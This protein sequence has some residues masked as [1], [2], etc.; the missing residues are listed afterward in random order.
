MTMD[1]QL[2]QELEGML[3]DNEGR[4]GAVAR[5][6]IER[7][8]SNR[9]LVEAGG[10]ANQGAA[11]NT[12]ATV[13]AI[14]EGTIPTSPSV[15]QQARR[16]VSNLLKT[17]T[18][19]SAMAIDYLTELRDRL[20]ERV[21]DA[22]SVE[23]EN[24]NLERADKVLKESLEKQPG[25]YVYTTP[26]YF[27]SLQKSD[28]DRFWFKVGKTDRAAGVR[29]GEQMRATG[30]PENPFLARVYRHGTMAPAEVEAKY[31][32]LLDAAG[33]DRSGARHAGREWFATNLEFLDAIA[34][35]L[36]CE[37]AM[38]VMEGEE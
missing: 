21:S 34:T 6:W 32:L 31:H 20:E 28:P 8:R 4:L 30:L 12:R 23:L 24:E 7:P 35:V 5:L 13:Q 38:G 27:R 29:I 9:E 33:H 25:V 36:G 37:I 10:G 16:A 26:V 15:A 2:R 19:A 1:T 14:L 11:A 18:G 3:S 17:N 22:T